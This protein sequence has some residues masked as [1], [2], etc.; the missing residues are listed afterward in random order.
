M[1]RGHSPAP[2]R[3]LNDGPQAER[4]RL[5][6]ALSCCP[7][8]LQKRAQAAGI[9]GVEFFAAHP[10]IA[11]TG[12]FGRMEADWT[13]PLSTVLVRSADRH[14]MY[15]RNMHIS[16]AAKQALLQLGCWR[17]M[18]ASR[19]LCAL[20]MVQ[21]WSTCCHSLAVNLSKAG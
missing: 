16:G 14:S 11:K 4:L 10:G 21:S 19:L 17:C 5:N 12:I 20:P 6:G 1:V 18:H 13:K 15:C 2:H 3:R 7:Q 8:E 9:N